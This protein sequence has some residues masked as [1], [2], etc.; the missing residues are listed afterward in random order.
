MQAGI[1]QRIFEDH[2]P[3]YR[4]TQNLS[5]RERNAAHQILTCRTPAQGTHGVSCPAGDFEET[6]NN[7]CKHRSC[8]QCG[9]PESFAWADKWQSVALRCRY[10]QAVF[11]IPDALH[12]LWAYNRELFVNLLFR[13]AWKTLVAFFRDKE[14]LGAE[15]GAL[16]VFQS[17]GETLNTHVH[18]HFLITSGGLTAEGAWAE[19]KQS[20]LLPARAVSVKFRGKLR[21]MLLAALESKELVLPP[22]KDELYWKTE[23]N[24][25]GRV[26]WHVQIEPAYE[27]PGG[28][29][30]YLARYL[31]RGPIA[32]SRIRR[33]AGD[34][35]Q[36]AYKRQDEHAHGT[37]KLDSKDFIRRILTHVP[38]KGQRVARA[39]GL[40]HHHC[41]EALNN[42]R[43]I[44]LQSP[45]LA[46][47]PRLAGSV[48]RDSAKRVRP[49]AGRCPKCKRPLLVTFV[50]YPARDSPER[51]VA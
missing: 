15:V 16:G 25:L 24:R 17:W 13:A 37:F 47:A 20:F 29:I 3:A 46:P 21:S 33:Y 48:D 18:L 51:L 8:P 6:R 27:Q 50:R 45:I 30:L 12:L 32:E 19:A 43:A 23:L 36:V 41:R 31:R 14:W 10:H 7:S 38:A 40:F 26:K 42:A 4:R 28:L 1:I 11:T 2:Y 49:G 39:Y 34:E 9:G 44:L 22:G 35:I 5:W